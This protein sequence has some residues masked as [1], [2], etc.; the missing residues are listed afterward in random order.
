MLSSAIFSSDWKQQRRHEKNMEPQIHSE[1]SF[2]WDSGSDL[3]SRGARPDH[4][5]RRPHAQDVEPP[6][7]R[8]CQK[9]RMP[10]LRHHLILCFCF[11]IIKRTDALSSACRAAAAERRWLKRKAR[12]F[13]WKLV[14]SE[15]VSVAVPSHDTVTGN[16][17]HV[18][19]RA[20]DTASQ[21]LLLPCH[22]SA[23]HTQSGSDL[24]FR[25]LKSF[26]RGTVTVNKTI[27]QCDVS[28][29]VQRHIKAFNQ[30]FDIYSL[31]VSSVCHNKMQIVCLQK[32]VLRCGTDLHFQGSQVKNNKNK[33]RHE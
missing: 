21:D 33:T 27:K 25:K 12:L 23:A 22:N 9:V 15:L 17:S 6:K 14:R 26:L 2:W 3:P 30:V 13:D 28:S 19:Q 18:W 24:D 16:R 7:D 20:D 32:Y 29:V 11:L 1:E 5:F 4:R 8:S 10:L 31:L